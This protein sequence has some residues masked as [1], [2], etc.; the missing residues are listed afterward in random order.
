MPRAHQNWV[1]TKQ[2]ATMADIEFNPRFTKPKLW[3]V[4]KKELKNSPEYCIDQLTAEREKDIIIKR[5][6][7]YHCELKKI[8][9][10]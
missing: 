9:M 2:Y 5:T 8:A 3:E 10:C 6:P 7:P 4:F 1:F